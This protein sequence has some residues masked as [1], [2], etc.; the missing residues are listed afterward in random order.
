MEE[1]ADLASGE[2]VGTAGGATGGCV[3]IF[4][5]DTRQMVAVFSGTAG[6][7]AGITPAEAEAGRGDEAATGVD[8][9]G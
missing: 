1:Y 7:F 3:C 2:V 6:L 5:F 4:L 9:R 8:P